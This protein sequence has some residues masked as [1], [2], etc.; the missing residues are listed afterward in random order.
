M[1]LKTMLITLN[2]FANETVYLGLVRKQLRETFMLKL[3]IQFRATTAPHWVTVNI[4][5]FSCLH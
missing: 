1:R 5:A 3:Q 2:W 4:L